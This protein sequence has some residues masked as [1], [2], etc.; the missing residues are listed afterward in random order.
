MDKAELIA[1]ACSHQALLDAG[2]R[3]QVKDEKKNTFTIENADAEQWTV[4]CGTG[5]GGIASFSSNQGNHCGLAPLG[6]LKQLGHDLEKAGA[7]ADILARVEEAEQYFRMP[8]KFHPM[9]VAMT[10]ANGCSACV[11]IKYGLTGSNATV[12]MACAAGTA[13]IGRSFRAIS[14]GESDC[15]LAGGV[16]YLGDDFGGCFRGFDVA[17]TLVQS[18]D[19]DKANRPFDQDRSGFLFA[20]GGGGMLVLEEREHAINRGARIYA[21]ITGFA[22]TFDAYSLMA[23]EPKALGAARMIDAALHEAEIGKEEIGY[24]NAHGTGTILN[25]EVESALIERVFDS[26]PLVNSTKSLVGHT[27]G[28]S[29]AIEAAVTALSLRNQTTHISRNIEKPVRDLNFVQKAGPCRIGHALTQ[30]FAFGGHN[31][32]LV[33]SRA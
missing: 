1:L 33:M 32:C 30:S 17:R 3:L 24:V 10:M 25:D 6:F 13:A 7:A 27:I 11:G 19:P 4:S 15:A 31:A 12:S 8:A 9:T 2:F 29:G 26:R 20:E 18:S 14:R 23:M 16:E 28:A 5:I 21:E 22:E